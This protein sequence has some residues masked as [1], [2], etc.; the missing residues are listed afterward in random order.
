MQAISSSE[1]S[2][3]SPPS[4]LVYLLLDRLLDR[5]A[6]ATEPLKPPRGK[7]DGTAGMQPEE[8]VQRRPAHDL[9]EGVLPRRAADLPD[10]A[11]WQAPLP[12]HHVAETGQHAAI[13]GI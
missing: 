4:S 1:A 13:N 10:A 5:R 2:T 8:P 9:R 12:A 3:H 7:P 6:F 11:V